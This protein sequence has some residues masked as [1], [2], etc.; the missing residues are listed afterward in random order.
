MWLGL[1]S[2]SRTDPQRV[3]KFWVCRK[4]CK[5]R[6]WSFGNISRSPLEGLDFKMTG[7]GE[8]VRELLLASA[9]RT[10]ARVPWEHWNGRLAKLWEPTAI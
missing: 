1:L 9:G 8:A 4:S 5:H 3:Q 6:K 7:P 10:A 2:H